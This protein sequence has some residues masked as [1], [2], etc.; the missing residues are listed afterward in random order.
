VSTTNVHYKGRIGCSLKDLWQTQAPVC[1]GEGKSNILW[2]LVWVR[3]VKRPPRKIT[4]VA[5]WTQLRQLRLEA[6]RSSLP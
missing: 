1:F 3:L 6:R 4:V 5:H 2:R